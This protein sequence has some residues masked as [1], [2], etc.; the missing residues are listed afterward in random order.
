VADNHNSPEIIF[1]INYDGDHTQAFAI[2]QVMIFGNAGNGG[3][4]G[5]R[6]TSGLS[7]KF[8]VPSDYRELFAKE[9]KGQTREIT[10]VNQSKEGYG[11]FKFRKENKDGSPGFTGDFPDTDFPL[12]R[13]ADAYLMYAE[14]VN[15]GGTGGDLA[16]AADYINALRTRDGET[17][18]PTIT[19]ATLSGASGLQFILDER[20]RE[21]Y[22]EGHRRT[23]LIRFGQFTG[24]AYVW[25]W[26]GNVLNGTSTPAH[27]NIFPIPSN[28][29]GANPKL[30]QN[31]GY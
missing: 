29:L 1:P 19:A 4:S 2:T 21:L 23:D 3:W 20:A 11:V 15:R 5:L 18:L 10:A 12:F 17:P 27:L 26:K 8:T 13:L 9:D 31:T 22:W 25:P 28:D 24:D 14:A 30:E 16:T 7:D 6:A